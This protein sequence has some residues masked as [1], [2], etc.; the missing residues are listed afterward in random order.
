MSTPTFLQPLTINPQK[1]TIKTKFFS[2][3]LK[4]FFFQ[5]FLQINFS[6]VLPDISK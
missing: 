5:N 4:N 6:D 1:K 2:Q 3:K